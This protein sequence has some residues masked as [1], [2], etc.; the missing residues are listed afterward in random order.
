ML[1]L[2]RRPWMKRLQRRWLL[3]VPEHKREAAWDSVVRQNW[4]ARKYGLKMLTLSYNLLLGSI[5]ITWSY[6]LLL[7]LQEKG[8]LSPLEQER[9][10]ARI[11]R[12]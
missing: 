3:M 4:F 5:L 7:T 9:M 10:Q 8:Y 11:M 1:W 6:M 12:R 2:M